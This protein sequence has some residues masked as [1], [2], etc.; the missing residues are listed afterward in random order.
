MPPDPPA[1]GQGQRTPDT[2][3]DEIALQRLP[4]PRTSATLGPQYTS[5]DFIPIAPQDF[6]RYDR[7]RHIKRIATDYVLPPVSRIIHRE[8]LAEWILHEHPEG[9][10]YFRHKDQNVFT[11]IDLYDPAALVR[12]AFCKEQILR[13]PKADWLLRSGNVDLVLD[14]LTYDKTRL[15]CAYY[16]ADHAERVV[17]WIDDFSMRNLYVWKRVPGITTATHVKVALEVEYW[18]HLEYFPSR[19]PVSRTVLKELKGLIVFG[20][21]DT[22][23]SPT[24]IF[25]VPTEHLFQMLSV[26]DTLSADIESERQTED[27]AAVIIVKPWGAVIARFMRQFALGRFYNFNGETSARLDSTTSVYGHVSEVSSS[28]IFLSPLLFNS[29]RT[30]LDNIHTMYSDGIL[31]CMGWKHFI[32]QLRSEWQDTILF[33]TLILN[34]NV[35]FLAISSGTIPLKPPA[36]ILSYISVFFGLG[37]VMTAMFLGRQYRQENRDAG[38]TQ[39]AAPFF[40]RRSIIGFQSLAMLYSLPYALMIWGM[41]TFL[42]AFFTLTIQSTTGAGRGLVVVVFSVVLV[43]AVGHLI[44]ENVVRFARGNIIP[45]KFAS[46][47]WAIFSI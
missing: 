35:G 28:F 31:N 36:Q 47:I 12:L 37:S 27:N 22:M 25:P 40:A 1:H 2:L 15:K 18:R 42:L 29:P 20:I 3:V 30:H 21:T 45:R 32:Q 16:F 26:V 43:V 4:P 7:C 10:L 23:T 6:N 41:L 14:I 44:A 17:F 19:F 5:V 34:A 8:P 9:A 38:F 13:R 46:R 33:G 11:D 24:T 39:I